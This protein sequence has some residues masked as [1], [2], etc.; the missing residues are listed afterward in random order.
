MSIQATPA[1]SFAPANLIIRATVEKNQENRSVEIIAESMAFYRSSEVTIFGDRGPRVT[2]TRLG[3]VPGGYY[4]VRAI[5]K[6]AG[7]AELA[8]ARTVVRVLDHVDVP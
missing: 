7:G 3:S 4:E 1:V 5:L 8:A 2:T 6:G